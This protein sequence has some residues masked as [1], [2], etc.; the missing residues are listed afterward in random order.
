MDTEAAIVVTGHNVEAPDLY[1]AHITEKLARLQRYN[2]HVI[3]Y[4]V[5]LDHKHNPRQSKT[6]QH[7]AIT[8]R[9]TG[10]AIRAEAR[11]PDF[12]AALDA[13]VGKLEEGL[14]RRHD[15]QRVRRD[16]RQRPVIDSIRASRR[17][18]TRSTSNN[19]TA[20]AP[21]PRDQQ[22]T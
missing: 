20:S 21:H 19:A 1:R 2:G 18:T 16:R 22:D 8:C 7:V 10:R 14:R 3:R 9:T 4:E 15:R 5:E 13:A 11:G 6:C 12:H 17:T